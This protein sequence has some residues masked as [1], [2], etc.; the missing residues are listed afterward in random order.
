M[1][2]TSTEE[3]ML[4]TSAEEEGEIGGALANEGSSMNNSRTNQ[5]YPI[6]VITTPRKL[7]RYADSS[8][9]NN[10]NNNNWRKVDEN[11]NDVSSFR[12]A[13][14]NYRRGFM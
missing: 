12:F 2:L 11:A 3:G 7:R 13:L 8:H 4:Q 6:P 14:S 5:V 10:N 9:A 1:L